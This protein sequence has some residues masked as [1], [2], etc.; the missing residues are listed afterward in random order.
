MHL[1]YTKKDQMEKKMAI[2]NKIFYSEL[3]EICNR[4]LDASDSEE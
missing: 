3:I 1:L 2:N 4:C